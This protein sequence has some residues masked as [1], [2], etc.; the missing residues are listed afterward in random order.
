MGA[1]AADRQKDWRGLYTPAERRRKFGVS[2]LLPHEVVG[3]VVPV[4]P[5]P[6]PTRQPKLARAC[7]LLRRELAGGERTAVEL[8]ALAREA[9]VSKRTFDSAKRLLGVADTRHAFGGPVWWKPPNRTEFR[10]VP[11]EDALRLLRYRRARAKAK[12]LVART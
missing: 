3:V 8:Y 10:W 12:R 2:T 5:E 4:H 6:H 7:Q 11:R 1:A 9:G